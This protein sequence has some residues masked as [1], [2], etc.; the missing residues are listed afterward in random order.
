MAP[1][2]PLEDFLRPLH[3]DT[4]KIHSLASSLA[5]TYTHLAAESQDQFLPTPISE[6]ILTFE[7]GLEGK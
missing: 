7:G 5:R 6:E 1:V 4:T 2:L 3:I